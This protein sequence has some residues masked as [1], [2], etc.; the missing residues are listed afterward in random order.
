VKNSPKGRPSAGG[1][2]RKGLLLLV[3]IACLLWDPKFPKGPP[4]DFIEKEMNPVHASKHIYLKFP[5][6]SLLI[7][8]SF[9]QV[10]ELRYSL[11]NQHIER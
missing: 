3:G 6:M 10:S 11:C 8:S 5:F 9:F 4:L 7:W 1:L 2:L